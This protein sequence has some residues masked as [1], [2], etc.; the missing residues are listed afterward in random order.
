MKHEDHG[1]TFHVNE[2]SLGKRKRESIDGRAH[3]RDSDPSLHGTLRQPQAG[4]GEQRD[5]RIPGAPKRPP[6]GM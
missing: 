3:H 5:E 1:K 4:N 6:T 2:E